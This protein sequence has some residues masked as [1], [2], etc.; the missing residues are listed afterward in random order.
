MHNRDQF[1]LYL[2][3]GVTTVRN[4][5]G[6]EA[7]FHWRELINGNKILGPNIYTTS[8]IIDGYPP[9]WQT[10]KVIEQPEEVNTTHTQYK[11]KGY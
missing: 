3:N 5:W 10:S 6:V 4:M 7:D 8:P 1:I 9:F 2:Y 11:L